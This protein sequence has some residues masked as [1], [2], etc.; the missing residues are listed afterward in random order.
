V[1][2]ARFTVHCTD[3]GETR[4]WEKFQAGTWEPDTLAT[5]ARHTGANVHFF[6]IG[7]WIGPTA[8]FA[9]ANGSTVTAVEADPFA[10]ASLRRNIGLNPELAGSIEVV[11]RA[12]SPVPGR[13]R[14]GSRRKGGDSMS[15]LVHD[16]MQTAWEVDTITPAKL[17]G[18]CPQ[19]K[20][21]FL[22]IDIEGGEYVILDKADALLSLPLSGV[23]LSLHPQMLL[24]ETRGMARLA[25]WLQAAR[26]TARVFKRLGHMQISQSDHEPGSRLRIVQWLAP[27]GLC[28]WPFKGSWLFEPR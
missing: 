3:D 28:Y 6:D 19:G 24:G 26:V 10:L 11:D 27:L 16:N 5:I 15:S 25:R 17:A 4:F 13:I 22:K 21:A 2:G 12:L 14:F 20:T 23:H 1:G 9:A 18:H 7:T 8:L